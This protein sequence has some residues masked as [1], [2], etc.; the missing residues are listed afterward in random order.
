ME[1]QLEALLAEKPL[2][3]KKPD[4]DEFWKDTLDRRLVYPLEPELK[5]VQYPVKGIRVYDLSYNGFENRRVG[6]WFIL[7]E[8]ASEKQTVPALLYFSGYTWARGYVSQYLSWALQGY[9]VL[10]MDNRGQGGPTPEYGRYTAGSMPGWFTKGIEDKSNYYYRGVFMDGIRALDFLLSRPEITKESVG[11]MGGSQG[12][13]TVLA[14]AGLDSRPAFALCTFPFL[15][16]VEK[17]FELASSHPYLELADYFKLFD[18]ELKKKSAVFDTLSYYD[19][20]NFASDITCPVLFAVGLKD[21]VCPP[22]TTL[23]AYNHLK[24]EKE[25]V[26]YPLHGHEELFPLDDRTFEFVSKYVKNK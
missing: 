21:T 17:A 2:L 6:G 10:A 5:P 19:G 14:V 11:L 8:G 16:H 7:P 18:P 1:K 12:G 26:A 20:M 3:T 23:A 4:Y 15:C 22:A 25:L 9:A 13:A 24:G